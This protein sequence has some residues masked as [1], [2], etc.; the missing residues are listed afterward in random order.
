MCVEGYFQAVINTKSSVRLGVN[1][2]QY[3]SVHGPPKIFGLNSRSVV[4]VTIV[5][6]HNAQRIESHT[7]AVEQLQLHH[8]TVTRQ[9]VEYK[10]ILAENI[11]HFK[12]HHITQ[13]CLLLVLSV[14]WLSS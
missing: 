7:S 6:P 11:L 14:H 5:K 3:I 12:A 1:G 2:Q 4:L 13:S 9:L 10:V 8:P